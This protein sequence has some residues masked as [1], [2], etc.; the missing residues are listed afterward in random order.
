L[1]PVA[2]HKFLLISAAMSSPAVPSFRQLLVFETVARTENVSRA[3]AAIHV[4]QPA[5]TQA[6]AQLENEVGTPLFR[7][8]NTGCYLTEAGGILQRRTARL[9]AQLEQALAELG[10]GMPRVG[11]AQLRS[12]ERKLSRP[13]MRALL[14]IAENGSFAAAARAL[15]MSQPSIH[16]A[17][18]ELERVLRR[19]LF[20]RTV[21][22]LTATQPAAEFARQVRLAVQELERAVEEIEASQGRSRARI[23]LGLL[24]Q[25][26]AFFV[27]RALK[28]LGESY[29]DTRI[30]VI[31]GNF[32]F[33]IKRLRSGGID[34][35]IGPVRGLNLSFG[36]V[37]TV[38]FDDPYALVVRRGHPLT[39]KR[40]IRRRD[41]LDYDW[42]APP[43]DAPRRVV[44]DALFA[45]LD[46][47]P[48][49]TLQTSSPN[50]TRAILTET[51]CITLLSRHE[52]RAEG[53]MGFLTVLPF[54]VPHQARQVQVTTRADW[55]PTAVQL[56]F[57]QALHD[58][59][60][61]PEGAAPVSR[62]GTRLAAHS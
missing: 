37:E 60:H 27:A 2:D 58:Q 50:L 49:S 35:I 55:L 31:D 38:L 16:R 34:F 46:R 39:R 24:P 17:A 14:A 9:F 40:Q 57:L 6:I 54:A 36:V 43:P 62:T 21:H 56:R 52:S 18:R 44:Y 28:D 23:G 51:D 13:H 12:L 53:E 30:E 11:P 22:G 5:V 45:G 8:R 19:P 42:I 1:K 61:S 41:L 3:A 59:A 15:A 10:M 47:M 33:L 4:S 25:A 20:Q 32:D 26:G 29:P 7:R 48:R